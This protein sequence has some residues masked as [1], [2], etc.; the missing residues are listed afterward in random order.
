MRWRLTRTNQLTDRQDPV[1]LDFRGRRLF[2]RE[3]RELNVSFGRSH[4]PAAKT[5]S[6]VPHWADD[7]ANSADILEHSAEASVVP[8]WTSTV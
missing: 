8:V 7:R 1:E 5:G 4:H 3:C 6:V 2:F